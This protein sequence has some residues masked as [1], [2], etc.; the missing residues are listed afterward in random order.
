MK[1]WEYFQVANRLK[2]ANH[3]LQILLILSFIVGLNY[4]ALNSFTRIDLTEDHHYAL[5]PESK[6]Y[7]QELTDPVR[8]VVTIPRNSPR[9]EEQV[10]FRYVSEL[11]SEYSYASQQ[12]GQF[13]V[14]PEYVDIYQ[15]LARAD[16]LS[17]NYGLDQVNSLLVLSGERRRL[18][19]GSEILTFENTKPVAFNGEAILTSAIM[20]VSQ[21]AS[22][23]LYFLN[24]HQEVLPGDPSPSRGLSKLSHELQLRN[25]SLELLDLTAVKS[26][27]D[28]CSV[29]VIADPMGP[30]LPSEVDQIRDYLIEDAG[31]VILW[32]RPGRDPALD[33][34]LAEWGIA[35]P[36][37]LV[38][39]PDSAYLDTSGTLLI[40][41]FGENPITN[42]LINNQ[43]F[44]VSGI[45]RPVFP[46]PPEPADERLHFIPLFATSATSWSDSTYQ[47]QAN[48]VFDLVSDVRGPIPIAASVDRR[49]SSQLGISVP[50]G[51]LVVFGSPDLFSNQRIS[52]LGNVHLFFN[53][54]N[55]L[56]D[57]ERR[58]VIPP[59]SIEVYKLSLSQNDLL[60][61]AFFFFSIP[62]SIILLGTFVFWIRQS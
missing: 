32:T 22:P 34:L 30:L 39:E 4:L 15:D 50:G 25:F 52:S 43:T 59:R 14:T 55:W 3:W 29:L 38:V 26:V 49:A 2:F 7:L 28:D 17:R 8:I 62:A 31:K 5:S 16:A 53:T 54:L 9:S 24:G 48:P 1:K 13:M 10:L 6:A 60:R 11:L 27:P 47:S 19:R 40:R 33:S 46:I 35:I 56:M 18:V 23:K 12:N 45:A 41:N 21:E 57:W 20:E 61:I 58:L 51:R 37:Q 36:D 44:V 42:S